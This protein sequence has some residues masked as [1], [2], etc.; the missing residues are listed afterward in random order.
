LENGG[1]IAFCR[2][3]QKL[4]WFDDGQAGCGVPV[5]S[6]V[7]ATSKRSKRE[8]SWQG[9]VSIATLD[10]QIFLVVD[11]LPFGPTTRHDDGA[12]AEPMTPLACEAC[13]FIQAD[14]NHNSS[15]CGTASSSIHRKCFVLEDR[16]V[17]ILVPINGP[18]QRLDQSYVSAK[19]RPR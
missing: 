2:C 15:A 7:V 13:L 6:C 19:K 1:N 9:F 17:G 5:V 16:Q 4:P 10:N 12:S 18:N 8:K 14:T 3:G 11:Q